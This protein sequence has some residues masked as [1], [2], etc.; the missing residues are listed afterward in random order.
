MRKI[1]IAL[2]A[3]LLLIGCNGMS[4]HRRYIKKGL[5]ISG[6]NQFAFEKEWGIPDNQGTWTEE[7]GQLRIAIG[8][9][10]Q[11]FREGAD[12]TMMFG[13]TTNRI[14]YYSSVITD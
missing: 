9:G 11:M 2:I 4:K 12:Y 10:G 5:L 14:R 1:I 8:W 6:L 7:G 13:F 3:I